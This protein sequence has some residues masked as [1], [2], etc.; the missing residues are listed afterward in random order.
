MELNKY[1]VATLVA[2]WRKALEGVSAGTWLAVGGYLIPRKVFAEPLQ[3]I[4]FMVDQDAK[5]LAFARNNI[6]KLLNTLVDEHELKEHARRCC[7]QVEAT[8]FTLRARLAEAERVIEP[9][10]AL[11]DDVDR[12]R[13]ED[14]S[15]CLHRIRAAHLRAAR[16][17]KQGGADAGN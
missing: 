15:T 6:D 11:A 10:A 1:N 3:D 9:F 12:Y 4:H 2:E 13:H 14:D 7:D 17:W 16:A 8:I 5:F